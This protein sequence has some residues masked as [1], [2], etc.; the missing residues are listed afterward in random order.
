MGWIKVVAAEEVAEGTVAAFEVGER[1]VAIANVDGTIHAF[2]D[3]C[4]HRRCS[5]AEGELDGS[6]VSCPCHG[7][8]FDVTC[9][10][11]LEGPATEPVEVFEVRQ[12]EGSIEVAL[13]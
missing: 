5:L 4:T 3:A 8:E 10:E 12:V 7:A 13:P 1:K 9:G 11:V 2:D 6:V